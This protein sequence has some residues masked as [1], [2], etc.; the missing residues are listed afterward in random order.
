MEFQTHGI[1]RAFESS[2]AFRLFKATVP[3]FLFR[4]L[5]SSFIFY[6][7]K[8]SLTISSTVTQALY[9]G[10]FQLNQTYNVGT[11]PLF[12]KGVSNVQ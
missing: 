11:E 8:Y 6:F 7:E 2:F 5:Y 12:N 9:P 10:Y 4:Y 3:I 1:I